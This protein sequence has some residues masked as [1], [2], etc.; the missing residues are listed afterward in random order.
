MT[1]T[2]AASPPGPYFP[3]GRPLAESFDGETCG[4]TETFTGEPCELPAR[5]GRN[6]D[7]EPGD[8]ACVRHAGDEPKC[9]MATLHGG[10]CLLPAGF[11]RDGADSGPCHFHGEA[12]RA[13]RRVKMAEYL[14]WLAHDLTTRK[15]AEKTGIAQHTAWYWRR[16]NE[17]F[18]EACRRLLSGHVSAKRLQRIEET[19]FER[20]SDDRASSAER[21][22]ALVNLSSEGEGWRDVKLVKHQHDVRGGVLLAPASPDG[23]DWEEAARAQQERLREETGTGNADRAIEA[24]SRELPDG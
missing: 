20:A 7:A 23:S 5:Y 21:I 4:S 19:L 6:G 15:A 9:G 1:S 22:F 3:S 13:D 16:V 8:T 14:G 2:Q 24:R 10:P 12:A 17:D 18:D 11:G